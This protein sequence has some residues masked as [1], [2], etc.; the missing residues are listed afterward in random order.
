MNTYFETLKTKQRELRKDFDESLGLRVHRALSWLARAEQEDEDMDARF[1]FLWIGFNAAYASELEDRAQFSERGLF[2]KFIQRIVDMDQQERLYNLM[3]REFSQSIRLL[4]DNPYIY[5]PFWDYHNGNITEGD[6][7]ERFERHKLHAHRALSQHNTSQLL[8]IVLE[9]LYTLRNQLVHGGAT[10]NSSVNRE[11]LRD[12]ANILHKI[13]PVI[14]DIM[15]DSGKTMW[16]S[17]CY[18]VIEAI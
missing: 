6:W 16:G 7:K 2:G 4:I 17:P 18:P 14:I 8:L 12:G 11:Q 5:Q 10:W 13:L 1:I 15:M 9:R 3:W